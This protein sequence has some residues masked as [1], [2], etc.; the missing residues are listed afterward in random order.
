MNYQQRSLSMLNGIELIVAL[1]DGMVRFLYRGI[2]AIEAGDVRNRRQ[3]IKRVFDILIHLQ[4]RLRMDVGGTPARALSDFYTAM[5]ALA[6]Q[7]SQEQSTAKLLEAI[8]C[9]RNV[10]EAWQQIALDPAA[11]KVIPPNLRTIEE[12]ISSAA[13]PLVKTK[14]ERY[15]GG[16]GALPDSCRW[17][18]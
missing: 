2:E 17:M 3:A 11:Q 13:L 12:R 18:A 7:G 9:I 15:D 16:D 8:G 5:F 6:L 10:R 14:Q 1:Y 4:A